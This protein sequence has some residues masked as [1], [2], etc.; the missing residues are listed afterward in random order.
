MF[1]R[2]ATILA[3]AVTLSVTAAPAAAQEIDYDH[4]IAVAGS[5]ATASQTMAREALL[6]A[7][8]ID[9]EARLE[10]LR[11]WHGMFDRTLIGLRDGDDVLGLPAAPTPEIVAEIDL[12]GTYWQTAKAVFRDG[13]AAG[14]ITAAQVDVIAA[15]STELM[16]VFQGVATRY[17]DEAAKNRLTSM[18]ANAVLE[19]INGTLLSQRMATQ[20]LLVVYGHDVQANRLGLANSVVEFDRVLGNLVNGNLELRLLPPPNDEIRERLLR[21][22]RIWEDEFRPVIRRAL[23]TEPSSDMAVQMVEANGNL[24][25]QMK[26]ITNLYVGL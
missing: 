12:A 19:S 14:D 9:R 8:G 6:I 17:A 4:V 23:D 15:F 5:Q 24:L 10:S 26:A 22:Q 18:L 1:G 21:A 11:Y 16:T 25:Q 7:L 3:T 20:F 2:A 13:L